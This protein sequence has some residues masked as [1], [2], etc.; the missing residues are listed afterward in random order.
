MAD[1]LSLKMSSLEIGRDGNWFQ[2][3]IGPASF[4]S[5]KMF[6]NSA[7]QQDVAVLCSSDYENKHNPW[8]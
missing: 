5:W 8:H 3:D 2:S 4:P 7:Y 6:I 1:F